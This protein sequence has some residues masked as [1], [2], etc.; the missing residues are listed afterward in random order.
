MVVGRST[1]V[2]GLVWYGLTNLLLYFSCRHVCSCSFKL[3]LQT[4]RHTDIQTDRQSFILQTCCRGL[5]SGRP[6]NTQKNTFHSSVAIA[7][8]LLLL[9]RTQLST[10]ACPNIWLP[11]TLTSVQLQLIIAKLCLAMVT[12]SPSNDSPQYKNNIIIVLSKLIQ[13]LVIALSWNR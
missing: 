9:L 1:L 12:Y 13:K 5:P 7:C 10:K 2:S 8:I 11:K 4:Y 6:N 3:W